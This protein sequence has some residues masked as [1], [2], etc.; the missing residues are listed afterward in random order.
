MNDNI[1]KPERSRT[2]PM[3][4]KQKAAGQDYFIT[5]PQISYSTC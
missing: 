1:Q 3:T 2:V 5:S 4:K